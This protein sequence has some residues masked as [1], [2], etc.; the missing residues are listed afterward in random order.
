MGNTGYASV[1]PASTPI[2]YSS[3][4]E[5]L[6]DAQALDQNVAATM[7][8]HGN[9]DYFN[10][11]I[12]WDPAIPQQALPPSLFRSDK[13]AF[14]GSLAWPPFD[15]NAPPGSVDDANIARIPAGYRFVHGIDP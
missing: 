1:L 12:L 13:P 6:A 9:Y 3:Q 2:D 5:S 10:R 7:L 11:A 14:F 15:P 4:G 8:R